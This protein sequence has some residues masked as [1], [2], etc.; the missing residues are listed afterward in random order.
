MA[1]GL[2]AIDI[3]LSQFGNYRT[4]NGIMPARKA[5]ATVKIATMNKVSLSDALFSNV[6]K[7][8]LALV[9]GRP[10]RSFYMSEIVRTVRSGTGAVE[11]ELSRLER[12]GIV[13]VERIGNQ[14]HFRANRAS[15]IYGELYSLVQKTV[16]LNEPL[17]QSLEPYA[18]R[19]RSAFV[20]GSVAKQSDA[21]GSDIDLMVIGEGVGYS[22]L[23]SVLQDAESRLGRPINP[24]ILETGEWRRKRAQKNSFIEKIARQQKVFIFGSEADL[25]R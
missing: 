8:V 15:P 23:Y 19:I 25:A 1:T 9:F 24:T 22:E 7:R 10:E 18:D 3:A 11:R 13:C 12:S 20:Y 4:Q 6:Q 16:G 17:R 21:A 2:R 14:K 5:I